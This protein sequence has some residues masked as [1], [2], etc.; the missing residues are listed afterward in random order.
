MNISEANDTAR[1][2][3]LIAWYDQ[4]DPRVMGDDER[5][6]CARLADRA[7]RALQV[8]PGSIWRGAGS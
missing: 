7:A 3:A 2:L 6:V 1:L 4:R 5:A 8:A